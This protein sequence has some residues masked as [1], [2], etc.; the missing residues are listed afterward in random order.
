M[1]DRQELISRFA[2][3]VPHVETAILGKAW[4]FAR[5][6]SQFRWVTR[7]RGL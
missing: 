2:A 7:S 6:L 5:P 3:Y 1:T 4:D